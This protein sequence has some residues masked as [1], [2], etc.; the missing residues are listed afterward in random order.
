MTGR[1]FEEKLLQESRGEFAFKNKR[2]ADLKRFY[3]AK[4]VMAA[5]LGIPEAQVT[6]LFPIPQAAIDAS[7][8]DM[9]Q[10]PEHQ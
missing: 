10:N 1:K 2:W 8:D 4:S 6:L 7:P 9:T 5:H 3:A